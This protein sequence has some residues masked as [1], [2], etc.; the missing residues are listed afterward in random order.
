MKWVTRENVGID[1]MGSA[2]LIRRYI[3]P[4]AEFSFIAA[5]GRLDEKHGEPF[6]M[7][8]VRFSH[9]QGH[10]TF[11]TLVLHHKLSDPILH[12][13]ARIIDEADTVQ[14]VNVE[15]VAAG[16]DFICRG[17]RRTSADDQSALKRGA[18]IYEALYAEL[19]AETT[20]DEK[21][22][23]SGKSTGK[24]ESKGGP[25]KKSAAK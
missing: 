16:L 13:I 11:H 9:H 14:D 20:G 22:A 21:P 12:R 6:D 24:S 10:C 8:G 4:K 2:W 15:P 1:R 3:D 23:R 7:P 18:E 17:I 5:G 25:K 19:A